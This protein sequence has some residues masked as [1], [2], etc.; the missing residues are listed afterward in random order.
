M[1]QRV[2]AYTGS[3]TVEPKDGRGMGPP[4][5]SLAMVFD[6]NRRNGIKRGTN[7]EQVKRLNLNLTGSTG[8]EN[9]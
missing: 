5:D 7:T 1:V 6:G 3:N 9:K 8:V 2:Q 4:F